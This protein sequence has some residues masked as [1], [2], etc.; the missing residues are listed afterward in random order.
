MRE[1]WGRQVRVFAQCL[2]CG[3]PLKFSGQVTV[4]QLGLVAVL[5]A[6]VAGD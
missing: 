4:E 6:E 1:G 3:T 2:K 5:V